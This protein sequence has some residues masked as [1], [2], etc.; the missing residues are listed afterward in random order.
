[1]SIGCF[2]IIR[3]FG[4]W[5][6]LVVFLGFGVFIYCDDR[7]GVGYGVMCLIFFGDT[8]VKFIW[9]YVDGCC[10]FFLGFIK[11]DVFRGY[12]GFMVVVS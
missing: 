4:I 8:F 9:G 6:K 10:K 12:G 7:G 1:M 2:F 3:F 5:D 11:V